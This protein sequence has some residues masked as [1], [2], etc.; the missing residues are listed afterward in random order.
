M[1]SRDVEERGYLP[2]RKLQDLLIVNITR[3]QGLL[4]ILKSVLKG[5]DHQH[6]TKIAPS[7]F[8]AKNERTLQASRELWPTLSSSRST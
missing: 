3:L 2:L 6:D 1:R 4:Q 8:H 7:P 5:K